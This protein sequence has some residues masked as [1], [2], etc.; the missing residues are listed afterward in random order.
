[1]EMD[2]DVL[3]IAGA[4]RDLRRMKPTELSIALPIGQVDTMD[5]I[6]RI[7]PCSMFEMSEA[8]R[9]NAS[10]ATRAV[11]PLVN[12]GYVE[13]RRSERDARTVIVQLTRE[14][15]RLERRLT[16]ER[17]ANVDRTLS[18][19]TPKERSVLADLLERMVQA[20]LARRTEK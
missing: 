10:T 16:E 3:R 9:I 6:A 14:G 13:R 15:R 4:W 19:F 1:V 12:A 20:S 7:G 17:L 2:D 8:L 5:V 18:E 11:E